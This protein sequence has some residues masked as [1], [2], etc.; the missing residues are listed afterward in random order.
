[1]KQ[2]GK[3]TAVITTT[4][5]V[6]AARVEI[7]WLR[8]FVGTAELAGAICLLTPWL[9]GL[10]AEGS[11]RHGRR[12]HHQRHGPAQQNIRQ[13]GLGGNISRLGAGAGL[14]AAG[15]EREAT[16]V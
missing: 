6:T 3:E 1:M 10:A 4:A 5:R 8:Y 11:R 14:L 13:L 7:Q 16:A 15:A 2:T 12:E 9:A